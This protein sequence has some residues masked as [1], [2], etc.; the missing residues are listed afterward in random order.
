[1]MIKILCFRNDEESLVSSECLQIAYLPTNKNHF[2]LLFSREI[3]ILDLELGQAIGSFA[4]ENNSPSFVQIIPCWHRDAFFCL[5]DNGSITL[6]LRRCPASIPYH[7]DD[8]NPDSLLTNKV[9]IE[10]CYDPKCH[11]DVF[12]L[13]RLCR[14]MGFSVNPSNEKEISL[15]LSDGRIL[16]WELTAEPIIKTIGGKNE[17]CP[18]NLGEMLQP[19][20]CF[21][22]NRSTTAS[23]KLKFTLNGMFEGVASNPTCL[24]MCPALTTKNWAVYK[25]FAAV[26]K[27]PSHVYLRS[28]TKYI[29]ESEGVVH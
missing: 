25:P 5:H 12:R 7:L 14:I 26:G 3:L 9:S 16:L 17:E 21:S 10:I 24:K 20:V 4:V 8:D 28:K 18:L 1:M 2:L 11:S 15:I 13:S 6:K 19:L 29:Q 27:N 23:L 22:G